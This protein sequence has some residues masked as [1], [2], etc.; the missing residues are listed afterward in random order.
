MDARRLIELGMPAQ[1]AKELADQ[2][3]KAATEVATDVATDVATG[4]AYTDEDAILAIAGK[5]EIAALD[6][7]SVAADIV[8][9]LQ[10]VPEGEGGGD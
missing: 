9:A 5:T 1:L 7:E 4:L 3:V 6:A 2:I 10:A 8:A